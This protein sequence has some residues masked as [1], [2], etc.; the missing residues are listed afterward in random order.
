VTHPETGPTADLDEEASSGTG[1]DERDR[2]VIVV[3]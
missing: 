2:I 3:R 1:L